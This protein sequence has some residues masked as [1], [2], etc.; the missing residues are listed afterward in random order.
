[1]EEQA[2]LETQVGTLT[3]I[4]KKLQLEKDQY[5]ETLRGESVLW[6][7]K[8]EKVLEEVNTLRVKKKHS[9]CQVWQLVISGASWWSCQR[10]SPQWG[11]QDRRVVAGV[12][13]EPGGTPAA[14]GAGEL[15]PLSTQGKAGGAAAGTA[16]GSR[17]LKLAG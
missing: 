12:A 14:P 6:K 10:Y 9:R 13:G 4:L 2:E 8:L 3:E 17:G 15:G 7:R 1:M 16:V 11:H 5:K